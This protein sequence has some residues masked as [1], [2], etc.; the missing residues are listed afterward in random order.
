MYDLLTCFTCGQPLGHLY[1]VYRKLVEKYSEIEPSSNSSP[2]IQTPEARA[3]LEL[4]QKHDFDTR[5]YCCRKTILCNYDIT[6]M[7]S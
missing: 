1:K 6:D 5:S 4:A 3:L 2:D 7:V